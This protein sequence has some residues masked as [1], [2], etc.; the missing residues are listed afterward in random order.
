VRERQ[1]GTSPLIL[2]NGEGRGAGWRPGG[3]S[4]SLRPNGNRRER[5]RPAAL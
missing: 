2:A 3:G 1:R 5:E 4:I